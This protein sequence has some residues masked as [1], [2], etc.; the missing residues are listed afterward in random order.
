MKNRRLVAMDQ[1]VRQLSTAVSTASL[2][3]AEHP[4]VV[5]LFTSARES[6][7]EA[8]GEDREISLLRV[9][10]QL[11]IGSQPMP[12]SLYVDRFARMLRISGIGHV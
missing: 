2:Y 5:R 1:C 3:S 12:A 9:D 8:I 4:Q 6:L 10:D 11:A 7:L